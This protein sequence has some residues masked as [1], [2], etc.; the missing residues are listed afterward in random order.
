MSWNLPDA[1]L[2]N[3]RVELR[4]V[5]LT[6]RAAFERI[7][8]D[9]EIWRYFVTRIETPAE[10]DTFMETA[11]KDTLSG[12]RNVFAITDRESGRIV[13][14]SA[15]GNLAEAERR[16]EIGW[17]WVATDMRRT[18]LNRAAKL[19][20]LDH[21]F[22]V[23]ECERVEFKTDVLNTVA[24]KGLISLGAQE[25]GVLRSFNYMPGGRRRDVVYFSILRD[26]WPTL[27]K[28]RFTTK[29]L[30]KGK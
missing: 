14:S 27:R 2:T 19:A 23:L 18:G 26:E 21:A 1:V 10:L 11:I 13:G 29:L 28:E 20:L 6:D 5:R 16:L 8:Y 30:P 22:D 7:V 25:E 17:S 3:D 9:E 4:R 24:R 12:V 15:Y